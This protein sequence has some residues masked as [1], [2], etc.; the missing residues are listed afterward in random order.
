M[1]FVVPPIDGIPAFDE[2]TEL[3]QWVLFS[4]DKRPFNPSNKLPA[5]TTSPKTWG[6]F[7]EAWRAGLN[8][9]SGKF[10]GVGFVFTSGSGIVGVDL[11]KCVDEN[12]FPLPW[13]GKIINQLNSYTEKSPSGKGYHIFIKGRLPGN[14]N[15]KGG[16]EMYSRERYFTVTADHIDGT[17]GTIEERQEELNA[18]YNEIFPSNGNH[19][20]PTAN[21]EGIVVDLDASP[22]FQKFNALLANDRK[23]KQTWEHRRTD[24]LRDGLPDMSS[25]DLSLAYFAVAHDWKDQEIADLIVAHRVQGGREKDIL[26]VQRVK[27]LEDTIRFARDANRDGV[28]DTDAISTHDIR[29]ARATN[30]PNE[31]LN[32]VSQQIGVEVSR[33]IMR[34]L[35]PSE[36]YFVI[37]GKEI[38]VGNMDQV[39]RQSH[40][41]ARIAEITRRMPDRLQ[42]N[43]WREYV[44]LILRV[45]EFEEA[46]DPKRELFEAMHSYFIKRTVFPA[47]EH[48]EAL[49]SSHPFYFEKCHWINL[50]N[51]WGYVDRNKLIK[52]ITFRDIQNRLTQ[53]G[54]KR[55]L[56]SATVHEERIQRRYWGG[57]LEE[58]D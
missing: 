15:K 39:S 44:N 23:F 43:R 35:D 28:S 14:R 53:V 11:D 5:S 16:V 12:G 20:T 25:H 58:W 26:K 10:K 24:L 32:Q 33:V 3:R 55:R 8:D 22:P 41:L 6:T 9:T 2:L 7:E 1:A 27:Y 37:D 40:V 45:A 36:F 57:I 49:H 4:K 31:Q 21:V 48:E 42:P 18:V 47:D 54:W 13:A 19:E 50:E 51:F 30:N 46:L 38:R 17:P 29:S 34:G 56:F 52:G